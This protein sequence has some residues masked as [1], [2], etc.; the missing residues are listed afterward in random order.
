M[1]RLQ[2][3]FVE[4]NKSKIILSLFSYFLEKAK[5][6]MQKIAYFRSMPKDNFLSGISAELRPLDCP[7]KNKRL[8]T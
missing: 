6:S 5:F 2:N 3:N 1:G 8:Y 4:K 7:C